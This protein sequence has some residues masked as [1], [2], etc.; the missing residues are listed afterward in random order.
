RKLSNHYLLSGPLDKLEAAKRG[1]ILFYREAELAP[2]R[3]TVAAA[4]YDAP[5]GRA[6]VG[7]GA[8]LVPSADV[9]KPR[10]ASVVIIARAEQNIA[11]ANESNTPFRFGQL[12]VYPNLGQPL[13][14]SVAKEM[15]LLLTVYVP[16]GEKSAP[17]LT[18]EIAQ[19]GR[20]LAKGALDLP[21][22]DDAGRIQTASTI[23]TDKLLPGEYQLIVTATNAQGTATRVEH[24]T[25][26]P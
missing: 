3:Y 5:T 9:T 19:S 22:P 25:I 13:R 26:Q 1:T 10:L 15:A 16:R 24:F 11:L 12:L 6:G 18:V 2:G 20:T 14:K 4:V 17:K 7:A 21:A 23:P 8:V